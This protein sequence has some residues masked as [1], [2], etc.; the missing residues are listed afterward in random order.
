VD[1][2]QETK[3]SGATPS[4]TALTEVG[5][6]GVVAVDVAVAPVTLGALVPIKLPVTTR[7]ATT[8]KTRRRYTIGVNRVTA[9]FA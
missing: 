5:G 8:A 2:F 3:T 9:C 1:G 4:C 7:R 6:K